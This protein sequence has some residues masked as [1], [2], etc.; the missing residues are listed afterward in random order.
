[1]KVGAVE[2]MVFGTAV[3]GIDNGVRWDSVGKRCGYGE[4]QKEK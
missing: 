4:R 3:R 1:M 2:P